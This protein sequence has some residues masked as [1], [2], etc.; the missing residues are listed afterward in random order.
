[1]TLAPTLAARTAAVLRHQGYSADQVAVALG[2]SPEEADAYADAYL[3]RHH[4]PGR[5]RTVAPMSLPRLGTK[6]SRAYLLRAGGLS[7][8][9]VARCIG[10]TQAAPLAHYYAAAYGLPRPTPPDYLQRDAWARAG[11]VRRV[12]RTGDPAARAYALARWPEL[13]A[14]LA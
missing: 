2:C 13:A 4:L 5:R 9:D 1:M 3:A 8:P 14:T 12:R 6:S 11:A 7:W 10:T